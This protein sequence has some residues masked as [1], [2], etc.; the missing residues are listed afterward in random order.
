MNATTVTASV[1]PALVTAAI[2][3]FSVSVRAAFFHPSI[4][5]DGCSNGERVSYEVRYP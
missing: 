4:G 1:P 5:L 3:I 2:A